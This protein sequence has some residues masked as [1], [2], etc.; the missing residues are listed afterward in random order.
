VQP[1][2]PAG[3]QSLVERAADQRVREGE[4]VGERAPL[5]DQPGVQR[6]VKGVEDRLGGERE[7]ALEEVDVELPTRDGRRTQHLQRAGLQL[8]EPRTDGAPHALGHDELVGVRGPVGHAAEHLAQEERV[9]LGLVDQPLDQGGRRVGEA[10]RDQLGGLR[11]S[12]PMQL[13]V[14]DVDVHTAPQPGDERR[15]ALAPVNRQDQQPVA[16][17]A[18]QQMAQ[19]VPSR[20]IGP[21]QIVERQDERALATGVGEHGCHGLEQAEAL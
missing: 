11:G 12:Q 16:A 21:L 1:G 18:S 15:G 3:A 4:L 19:Q 20:A 10:C 8:P 6:V 7:S 17:L 9:A 2:A 14:I 5:G 13:D